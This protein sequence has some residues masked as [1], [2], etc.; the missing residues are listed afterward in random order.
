MSPETWS[1]SRSSSTA[2]IA[3]AGWANVLF[4]HRG[5]AI[6]LGYQFGRQFFGGSPAICWAAALA[7]GAPVF[8]YY[9]SVITKLVVHP[10]AIEILKPLT[11]ASVAIPQVASVRITVHG[12]LNM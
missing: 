2:P 1:Y 7:I 9:T 4:A 10:G 12:H 6:L 8:W 11:G 5:I 3:R